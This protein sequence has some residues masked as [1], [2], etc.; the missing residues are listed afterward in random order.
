MKIF[1]KLIKKLNI[2][3]IK[4]YI[5]YL[6]LAGLND[7]NETDEMLKTLEFVEQNDHINYILK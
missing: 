6:Y 1:K 3:I 2:K 4:N 5:N 7:R